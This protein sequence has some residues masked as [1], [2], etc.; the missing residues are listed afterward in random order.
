MSYIGDS[1]IAENC[2]FG[3]GTVTANFRF[4]E[5][6]V[7]V[8][9]KGERI[10]T[11]RIKFGAIIGKNSKTGVNSCLMPGVK[12]GPNS[13]IGPGVTLMDD[14]EPNKIILVKEDSFIIKENKIKIKDEKKELLEKLLKKV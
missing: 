10:S 2:S 13:I 9:V 8:N 1:I 5:K 4:D 6:E 7:K 11:D 12:V 14:L 3:A